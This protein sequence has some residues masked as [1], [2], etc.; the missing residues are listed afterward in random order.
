[1]PIERHTVSSVLSKNTVYYVCDECGT[2]FETDKGTKISKGQKGDYA[3]CD[4]CMK[5]L[6]P[7]YRKISFTNPMNECMKRDMLDGLARWEAKR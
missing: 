5:K 4:E 1:M 2:R 7:N 3:Y 6:Y